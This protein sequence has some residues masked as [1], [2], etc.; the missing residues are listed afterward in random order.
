MYLS[1]VAFSFCVTI[2]SSIIVIIL[3]I[4]EPDDVDGT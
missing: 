1:E 4:I 2:L 3:K